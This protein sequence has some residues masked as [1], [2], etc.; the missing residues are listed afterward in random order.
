M[1]FNKLL[2]KNFLSIGNQVVEI[3][4]TDG[5]TV[6]TGENGN[7]KS[8]ICM[9]AI[10]F[11]LF[12]KSYS[13]KTKNNLINWH[14]GRDCFVEMYVEINDC[15][16]CIGRSIKC[17][18]KEEYY[19]S[20]NNENMDI[21]D[22]NTFNEMIY[23]LLN[24]NK[25]IFDQ[26]VFLSVQHYTPFLNMSPNNKREFL[27]N[28]FDL[29]IFDKMKIVFDDERKALSTEIQKT[30]AKINVVNEKTSFIEKEKSDKIED[31]NTILKTIE[32]NKSE[33]D[34]DTTIDYTSISE[35]RKELSLI[36]SKKINQKHGKDSIH[37]L[38]NEL[39][40]LNAN[41]DKIEKEKSEIVLIDVP[42]AKYEEIDIG[43]I[44]VKKV[45]LS[46]TL[47]E[48]DK[49]NH[50]RDYYLETDI[51]DSCGSTITDSLKNEKIEISLENIKLNITL[52]D[53]LISEI[54]DL[55]NKLK[56][57]KE[58]S[59]EINEVNKK[60]DSLKRKLKECEFMIGKYNQD[61]SKKIDEKKSI[62]VDNM[63]YSVLIDELNTRIEYI[64]S[65]MSL[66]QKVDSINEKIVFYHNEIEKIEKD[67]TIEKLNDQLNSR[68]DQVK[69]LSFKF[70]V[71][72]KL[73]L[74]VGDDGIKKYIINTRIP[75]LNKLAHDF[76]SKLDSEFYIRF[77]DNGTKV[78]IIKNTGI[79]V[80]Y[81]QLSTG[82]QQRINLSIMFIFLEYSRLS[83][84]TNFPMLNI[85]E[86][87]N[88][89]LDQEG[90]DSFM[91][92]LTEIKNN[93]K[94]INIITHNSEFKNYGDRHI[95]V[96]KK[97]DFSKY[98]IENES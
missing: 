18:D 66:K 48:I 96:E 78:D 61:L 81:T 42:K 51:C 16:Y 82:Q 2:V 59:K 83:T 87:L 89:S 21:T 20:K 79:K 1:K 24:I 6:W 86:I 62:K 17:K 44:S 36:E 40:E 72:S 67:D 95:I 26:T 7:G 13:G 15:E 33:I 8:T 70:N 29:H 23:E 34:Y 39:T 71:F 22:T 92:I 80:D 10:S 74:S 93:I 85:D 38:T 5:I 73:I 64:E 91:S 63:D 84:G 76:C 27:K 32:K 47:K 54:S 43:I 45:E 14:N 88:S 58:E 94:Y 98:I 37:K 9:D 30:E 97:N 65:N 68:K 77:H 57:W 31:Y 49:L 75:T 53:K 41:I 69:K 90:V 25:K 3:P 4:F 60:N 56:L 50:V 12:G 19:I 46:N 55:E 28:M 35:K 52:K 11:V